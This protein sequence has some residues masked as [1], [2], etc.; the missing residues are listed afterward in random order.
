ALITGGGKGIGRNIAE[1]L[2]VNGAKVAVIDIDE[3]ALISV[4]E[5]FTGK[6]INLLTKQANI[7]NKHEAKEKV[8]EIIATFGTIDILVNNAGIIKDNYLFKMTDD[9]WQSVIDVHLKGTFNITRE[10]QK[11]MVKN[12][13]GRIINLSSTSALGN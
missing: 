10:V 7:V 4:K 8:Q 6:G 13:F 9:D 11:I 12:N 2:A 1:H 5:A 3:K